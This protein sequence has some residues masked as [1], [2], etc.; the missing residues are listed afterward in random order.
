M[1]EKMAESL[2]KKIIPERKYE[3]TYLVNA[4]LTSSELNTL[5]DEMVSLVGKY[6]GKIVE[7]NDWGKKELAYP[8]KHHGRTLTEAIYTHL[9]VE[10][11]ANKVN[12]LTKEIELKKE[13]VR[14]LVVSA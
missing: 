6:K 13:I 4:G 3:V 9:V 2:I 12:D 11:S 7:T 14:S 5:R 1:K 8:I 10:L